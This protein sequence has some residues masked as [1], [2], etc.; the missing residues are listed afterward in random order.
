[1]YLPGQRIM[2]EP[3]VEVRDFTKVFTTHEHEIVAVDGVSFSVS[4][5]EFVA[6]LGP[7]GCGKSTVLNAIAT[8]VEP[9]RGAVLID[10][11]AMRF[12]R[13]HPNVG[14]VFQ[15]DT[16]FPWRTVEGNVGYALEVARVPAAERRQR[17]AMALEQAGLNG[18]GGLYPQSLSGGMRQRAALMRAL[19]AQPRILL[20][21]EPFG[22]LDAHTKIGMHRVLLRIWEQQR[23]SV[24][25]VTHDLAEALTLADRVILMSAR[26]GR[27][28][29][30]FAVDFP[31]PRDAIR[32]PET[33]AYSR[34][35][36]HIW[37]S[38]GEELGV[39]VAV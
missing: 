7:S 6:L 2:P 34:L 10:G 21:D 27:I 35:F 1:M 22:A 25:F 39:G 18:F 38:L 8:L 17:V 3:R 5:G 11:D 29:E 32:L 20:M 15:R 19:I 36:S 13:P 28:K 37:H 12:M 24:V 26:P 14:Y 30:E 33:E 16:L 9:S 4:D 31:R 23:Q